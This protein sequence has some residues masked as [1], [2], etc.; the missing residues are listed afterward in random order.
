ME[1][2]SLWVKNPLIFI[3]NSQKNDE[4]THVKSLTH[5]ASHNSLLKKQLIGSRLTFT[6][7]LKTMSDI[8]T[9]L[10]RFIFEQD[11]IIRD[12]KHGQTVSYLFQFCVK[13][14]YI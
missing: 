5:F 6:S 7:S 9:F 12:D 4:D 13:C 10:R 2:A 3:L 8:K 14:N 11:I 1:I